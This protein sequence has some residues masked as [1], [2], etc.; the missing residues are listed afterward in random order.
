MKNKI[1]DIVDEID[2]KEDLKELINNEIYFY[3]VTIKSAR[4]NYY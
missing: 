3:D 2:S 4:N 1:F